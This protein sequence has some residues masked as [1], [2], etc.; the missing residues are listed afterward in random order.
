MQTLV[1]TRPE[2]AV[3]RSWVLHLLLA[4][5]VGFVAALAKH[6]LDWRLGI[7]GSGGVG[8]IAVLVAGS[9]IS[10]R[11][12]TVA[13]AGVSMAVWGVPI[14]L[15][16]SLAY[17]A[18]LYGIAGATIDALRMLRLPVTRWWGSAVT[19]TVVHVAKYAFIVGNAWVSGI[20]R[21]FEIYGILAALRNHVVFGLSGGLLGWGVWRGGRRMGRWLAGRFS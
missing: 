2:A 7:P 10:P 5:A 9:L 4:F 18:M 1:R 16:H 3:R 19:G 21:N 6:Y 12:G 11:R 13:I 17:N 15:G 14:G 20:I 8:W